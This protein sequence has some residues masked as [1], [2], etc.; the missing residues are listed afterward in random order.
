LQKAIGPAGDVFVADLLAI[1]IQYADVHRSCM[2]INSTVICVNTGVYIHGFPPWV[3]YEFCRT[4][5]YD[6]GRR[7]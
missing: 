3:Y 6:S 2:K 5:I 7:P 4:V 1:L